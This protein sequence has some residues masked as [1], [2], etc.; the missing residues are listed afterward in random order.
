[1]KTIA[2][3]DISPYIEIKNYPL[4]TGM[5]EVRIRRSA[6]PIDNIF[7]IAGRPNAKRPFHFVNRLLGK[8]IP[9]RLADMQ[10][11]HRLLAKEILAK[12]LVF[13][14]LFVTFAEAAT[15]MGE[16]IF[17]EIC[18]NI[19]E[20]VCFQRTTRHHFDRPIAF[21]C[22]EHHSHAPYHYFYYPKEGSP[23]RTI[24]DTAKS[25][26][27]IDDEFTTANT[28]CSF[29]KNYLALNKNVLSIFFVCQTNWISHK[30]LQ[31]IASAFP[32]NI[33]FISL[34]DGDIE[35][36][37]NHLFFS[38][39]DNWNSEGNGYSMDLRVV[40]EIDSRF[41][42]LAA[43]ILSN[44]RMI[45]D[46]II[47]KPKRL[48]VLGTGEFNY[49]PFLYAQSLEYAG[50]DVTFYSTTRTP[51]LVGGIIDNV[52]NFKDN[53][54]EG[55]DNFLY[56]YNSKQYDNVIICYETPLP[57]VEHNLAE[58]INAHSVFFEQ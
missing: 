50:H 27:L 11:V 15:C 40:R 24:F 32:C 18:K 33:E 55:I 28:A 39:S 13:P 17:A 49:L 57:S 51:L 4:K 43:E 26:I 30:H 12:P 9:T 2:L 10:L 14:V 44:F 23:E 8:H 52:M 42:I 56:N 45:Q 58:T 1:M 5:L 19:S 37:P 38:N 6:I 48:L 35:F 31:E 25:I 53:Y 3:N 41:G 29:L 34:A 20:G 21:S 46:Y 36:F 7:G 22:L 16:S 54:G 47:T